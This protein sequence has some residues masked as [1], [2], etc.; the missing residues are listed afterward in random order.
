MKGKR[1]LEIINFL[2][3]R[4]V[5]NLKKPTSLQ[6]F[7]WVIFISVFVFKTNIEIIFI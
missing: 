1:L 2:M 3:M 5:L 4:R 6:N 7:V